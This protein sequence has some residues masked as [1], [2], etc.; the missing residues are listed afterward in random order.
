MKLLRVTEAAKLLGVKAS[1]IHQLERRGPPSWLPF[2]VDG[3]ADTSIKTS[4]NHTHQTEVNV[5]GTTSK[6]I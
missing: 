6:T 5:D 2:N 4:I 3:I 1:S